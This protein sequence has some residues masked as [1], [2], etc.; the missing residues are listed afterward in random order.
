VLIDG[1]PCRVV[2]IEISAPG[3]HGSAKMRITGMGIFDGHKKIII[4]PSDADV[5]VPILKKKKAQVVSVTGNNA[6]LMDADTYEV[7]ELPIPEDFAGKVA[8]GNEVETIEAMGKRA[9]SRLL[10]GA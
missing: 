9:I 1:V 3:K 7:Y 5:E 10:G 6:Q 8:A 4:K 2:Q